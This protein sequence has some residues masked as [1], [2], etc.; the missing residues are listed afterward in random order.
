MTPSEVKTTIVT[1]APAA[2]VG[3]GEQE[4]DKVSTLSGGIGVL[5]DIAAVEPEHITDEFVVYSTAMY[6]MTACVFPRFS[7]VANTV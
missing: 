1:G 4:N 5:G 2:G 6:F 7:M 3:D